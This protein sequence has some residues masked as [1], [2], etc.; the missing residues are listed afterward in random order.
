MAKM[1]ALFAQSSSSGE[2]AVLVVWL[3]VVAALAFIPAN[4][5][6]KKGY[7]AGGF[8]VFGLCFFLI[9]LIVAMVIK[10]KTSVSSAPLGGSAAVANTGISWTHT[11][12]RYMSG[13]TVQNPFY[14]IWDRQL[15]GP[16]TARFPY[17]E[18]GKA[19]A[20]ARFQELEPQGASVA[21]ATL[22]PPPSNTGG[23]GA[24]A[25]GPA[26]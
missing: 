10:D 23:S 3:L 20:F 6:K 13:Y 21:Q 26:G 7:S 2:G 11:G 8:Y 1:V 5:A 15:P 4:I 14:G 16:P 12:I 24:W 17:T 18:H 9:A 19:E 25:S 22:P